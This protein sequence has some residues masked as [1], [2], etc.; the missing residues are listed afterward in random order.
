MACVGRERLREGKKCTDKKIGAAEA[1]KPKKSAIFIQ[2]GSAE[3]GRWRI[4][5]VI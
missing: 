4:V 2:G 3:R 5:T 1:E